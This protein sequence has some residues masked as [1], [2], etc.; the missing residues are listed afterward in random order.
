MPEGVKL[1]IDVDNKGSIKVKELREQIGKAKA[2]VSQASKVIARGFNRI[3]SAAGQ[4]LAPVKR[5]GMAGKLALAG[6]GTAA[7]L[8]GAQFEQGMANV[9][10]VTNASATEL[11]ALEGEA[12]KL[13][14]STAFSANQASEAMFSLASA[15]QDVAQIKQTTGPVLLL[16][17]ALKAD[18]GPAA[19]LATATMSQFGKGVHEAEEVVNVLA[20]A[21][22]RSK[23]NFDRL[24]D[25]MSQVGVIA[26]VAGISLEGTVSALGLLVDKGLDAS[27]AGTGLKNVIAQLS[28]PNEKLKELL[29]GVSLESD[30]LAA[31]MERLG[32]TM[33]GPGDAFEAFGRIGAQAAATLAG[34]QDAWTDLKEN[35]TGTNEAQRQYNDQMNTVASQM[36]IIRSALEET[37][38]STFKAISPL[39]REAQAAMVT[40]IE[41]T[42]PIITGLVLFTAKWVKEN[43]ELIKSAVMMAAKILGVVV[44][45]SAVVKVVGILTTAWKVLWGAIQIGRG[46]IMTI[47]AAF[48]AMHIAALGPWGI[49]AAVVVGILAAIVIKVEGV[50]DDIKTAFTK[51]KD[52]VSTVFEKVKDKVVGF[53]ETIGGWLSKIIPG[54]EEFK[55]TAKGKVE[56]LAQ[57]AQDAIHTA[58]ENIK[59][60]TTGW[61]EDMKDKVAAAIAAMKDMGAAAGGGGG[62][63]SPEAPAAEAEFK[64]PAIQFTA[65]P[66]MNTGLYMQ[67]AEEI[68]AI[69]EA[70]NIKM[71]ASNSVHTQEWLDAR[72]SLIEAQYQREI[73]ADGVTKQ[74][75]A[76]AQVDRDAAMLESRI[77]H[78]QAALDHYM[79]THQMQMLALG[80]LEAGFDQFYVGLWD[81]EKSWQEKRKAIGEAAKRAFIR[82]SLQMIKAWIKHKLMSIAISQ[83]AEET[84]HKKSKLRGA[85]EGAVSA[86]KAFAG[87]P[88]IGPALGA[89]AA[90][91]AFAFL[92][93]FR[94]GGLVPGK[95]LAD[96]V[97][98]V[99][100]PGEFVVQAPAVNAVG[101]DTLSQINRTGRLPATPGDTFIFQFPLSGEPM[102]DEFREEVE[103]EV[104]PILEDLVRRRR[105]KLLVKGS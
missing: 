3:K 105:S 103:E 71:A 97:P 85:K 53:F 67:S 8:V 68:A 37:F 14:S 19:E 60:T 82:N 24:R 28:A 48:I 20:A 70:N 44:A 89:I 18:L 79:E 13:G 21:N 41:R 50:R 51:V 22:R 32:K 52:F 16:A 69:N 42:R 1:E 57:G 99:V 88:I 94:K 4:A 7:I 49:L 55:E 91:A 80:S 93:A 38:I 78:Q 84:A 25:S 36:K 46:V 61:V 66:A 100:A 104:S 81:R 73:E 10:A 9:K 102:D 29:G 87:V 17:G 30:G 27:S 23:L 35:I 62:A 58:G 40:F 63:P 96:S 26:D 59:N 92:I 77:M 11:A 31:V 90:A 75:I 76:Q 47:R 54:F 64:M 72:Q 101:A 15:G 12:R 34:Q 86:Y 33:K 95:G 39:I 5:L 45:V 43:K 74:Q 56:D 65:A 6:L 2:S 83:A 98:A